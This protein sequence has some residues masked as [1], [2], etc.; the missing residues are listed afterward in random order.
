MM[1]NKASVLKFKYLALGGIG[2]RGGAQRFFLLANDIPF[3]E[4]LV[5]GSDWGA[6]EKARVV[7]SGENP[8][9]TV[10]IIYASNLDEESAP[11]HLIQHIATARYLARVH[12]KTQGLSPYEEYVQDLVADEYQ[13]W[14]S[15]W[16]HHAFNTKSE[17]EKATYKTEKVPEY[18][19][20]FEELYKKYK[21]HEIYLSVSSQEKS[22]L[23][24]D[25]A[26]FGLVR[27]HILTGL[28]PQEDVAKYPSLAAAY[29]AFGDIPS[30]KA[31]IDSKN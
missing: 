1:I 21:T 17:D 20:K 11:A 28:L 8:C 3:E 29:Q 4:D 16:V 30:V 31:W 23:W 6:S 24:G 12:G 22:P 14:R 13:G 25:A 10:P 26:V 19:T 18:L 15:D 9:G 7:A 2:G 27:D 5:T